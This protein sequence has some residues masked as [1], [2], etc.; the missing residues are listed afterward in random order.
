M[1]QL[2]TVTGANIQVYEETKLSG[3]IEICLPDLVGRFLYH[4]YVYWALVKQGSSSWLN[5][6]LH[7]FALFAPAKK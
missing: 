2:A 1:T 7:F 3:N 5:S 6:R 4:V